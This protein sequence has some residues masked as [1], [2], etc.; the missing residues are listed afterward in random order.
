MQFI[1]SLSKSSMWKINMDKNGKKKIIRHD[2]VHITKTN[3]MMEE[4][5]ERVIR[6]E[7]QLSKA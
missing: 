6:G 3:K 4:Y 7:A 1:N 2:S 5:L